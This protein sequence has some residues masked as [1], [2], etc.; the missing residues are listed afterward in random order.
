MAGIEAPG[1]AYGLA[2]GFG[3]AARHASTAVPVTGPGEPVAS[4][5]ASMAGHRYESAAVIVV[6]VESVRCRS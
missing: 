2:T 5:L 6:S 3:T 1:D 4:V